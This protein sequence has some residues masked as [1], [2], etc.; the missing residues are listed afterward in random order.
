MIF[1]ARRAARQ[2]QDE[3]D[4]LQRTCDNQAARISALEQALAAMQAARSDDQRQL[5]YYRG[6]A[7]KLAC[8]STSVAHLATPSSTSPVNWARTAY[9][10]S[11]STTRR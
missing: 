9:V 6:V 1:G 2:L 8:F 3:R 5:G 10:P 4:R 7:S 11:R